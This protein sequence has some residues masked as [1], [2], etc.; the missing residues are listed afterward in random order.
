MNPILDEIDGGLFGFDLYDEKID[1]VATDW[2][3]EITL[4]R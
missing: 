4:R 3:A 1:H 2:R